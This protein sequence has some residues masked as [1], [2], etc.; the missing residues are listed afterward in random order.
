M[1]ELDPDKRGLKA[2]VNELMDGAAAAVDAADDAQ[3]DLLPLTRMAADRGIAV[4][5]PRRAGRPA[6]A[7]NR[8]TQEWRQFLLTMH[9]S[10]LQAMMQAYSM[11]TDELA[12]LLSCT[13]HEAFK[14]QM[15][16][17]KECAPYLHQKQPLAI[18]TGDQG[19]INLTINLGQ[20]GQVVD[21][22]AVEALA[23]EVLNTVDQE[24]EENQMF[25][26][27]E[28][29]NSNGLTSNGLGYDDEN[30]DDFGGGND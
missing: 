3:M 21:A 19:L 27:D 1:S 9:A 25:S 8:S 7:R 23:V 26:A 2:A 5:G 11:P 6:G 13:K 14:L 20:Q 18:D 12:K 22:K 17:A 24:S 15:Q 16:C 28:I 30:A 29:E 4:A 10:P